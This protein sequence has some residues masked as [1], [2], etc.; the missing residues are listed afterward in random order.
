MGR[1]IFGT[2]GIRGPAYLYPLDEPGAEQVGRAVAAQFGEAGSHI[3]IGRDPRESSLMLEQAVA[4][5]LTSQGINVTLLGVVPT[6]GL[7]YITRTTDAKA[8]VM[9]T[10]SHNPYTDNGIK[11]FSSEGTKLPDDVEA[12]LNNQVESSLPDKS[13]GEAKYDATIIKTYEDFLYASAGK[14]RFSKFKLA[15]DCANGAMSSV[16]PSLFLR[17]DADVI[18]LFDKPDGKNINSHCGATDTKALQTYVREHG[19]DMGIAFD[20]DG[21][22]VMMVDSRGMLLNGDHLLYLLA[23]C[24]HEPGVVA[25]T[26]SNMGFERA[27]HDHGIALQ[28][29]AVGDR[30]VVDGML[31]SGYQLG[32]EQSG[33]IIIGNFYQTGDGLLTAVQVLKEVLASGKSLAEW[34]DAITILPQALVNIHVTDK[35]V[36]NKPTV[37][38]IIQ[39]QNIVY[40]NNGRLVIRASGTEPL[41]RVMLEAPDAEKRIQSIVKQLTDEIK[42]Y[43]EN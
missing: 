30:Y 23:I 42:K 43:E 40:A 16:G 24:R 36:I 21:D 3:I 39:Q 19:L 26:M 12:A 1:E 33:H 20:G 9:I 10:A 4:K 41:I 8:G 25:T 14:T 31:E 13:T 7:A 22:R 5:G 37:Q 2:D 32:G 38:A 18:S 28:R 15:L 17:L 6:A 35:T 34:H 11:V 27:L 29:T